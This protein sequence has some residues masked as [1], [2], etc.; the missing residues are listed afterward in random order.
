MIVVTGGAGFIGSAVIHQLNQA[1]EER[2]LVVDSLKKSSKWRNLR[3]LRF[4]DYLEKEEF[5]EKHLAGL[6]R[7]IKAVVHLG[8][9]SVTTEEDASYLVRNNYRYTVEL[10]QAVADRRD[11]RFV[12]ASSAATYGDGAQGY[13]DDPGKL[14]ALRPLNMYGYSKQMVDLWVKR[15]GFFERGVGLKFFNVFGPNEYHKGEMRSVVHKAWEQIRGT[16]K[17]RLFRSE[18]PDYAHGEQKRDFVYVRDAA[19]VVTWMLDHREINGLFNCGTGKARTWNDLARSVFRALGKPEKIEYIPLPPDL[20]GRYQYFTQAEMG[21]L[22]RAGYNEEFT[23]L[24][25]AINDYVRNYLLKGRFLGD[26]GTA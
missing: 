18:R 6:L 3:A 7:E 20:Q 10:F 16:G 14:E 13:E 12:Y 25:E 9:C 1:G 22:R 15:H 2:I 23:S 4:L 17:L 11:I 5:L 26:P 24:E 8:A 21:K 19:R